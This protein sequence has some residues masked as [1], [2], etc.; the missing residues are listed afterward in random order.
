MADPNSSSKSSRKLLFLGGLVLGI[1]LIVMGSISLGR[2]SSPNQK[3]NIFAAGTNPD[4]NNDGVVDYKDLLRVLTV[5]GI[6]SPTAPEDLD[7][8]GKVNSADSGVIF[9]KLTSGSPSPT[10]TSGSPT[11]DQVLAWAQAYKTAHPGNGGKDWDIVSC[12]AGATRTKADLESDPDAVRLRSICGPGQLPVIPIIA[13]EYGG[14]DH[15]WI[16]PGA[17]ALVYC[18]YIPTQS[19]NSHWQYNAATDRVTADVYVKFPD[20]NPCRNNVGKDQIIAC[21]GDPTNSEILVDTAS[22]YDGADAGLPTLMNSSTE[23]FLIMPDG[24]KVQL[25]LNI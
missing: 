19:F 24:S 22:L 7:G 11:A 20:Q 21:L 12:C 23:L 25:L 13:W 2:Q 18:V 5:W 16:N 9:S 4:L 6:I 1:I 17:S 15:P 10:G 14:A 8:N 3:V